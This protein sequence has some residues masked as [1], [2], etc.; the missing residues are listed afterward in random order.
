MAV[1]FGED[2]GSSVEAL[3]EGNALDFIVPSWRHKKSAQ[4]WAEMI[5]ARRDALVAADRDD[6]QDEFLQIIQQ[7]KHSKL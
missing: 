3:V 4:E 5:L 6:L 2:M 1:A 7:K